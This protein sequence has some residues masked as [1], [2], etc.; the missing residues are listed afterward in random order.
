MFIL[1]IV[2]MLMLLTNNKFFLVHPIYPSYPLVRNLDSVSPFQ[3]FPDAFPDQY[4]SYL[5][6]IFTR[7]VFGPAGYDGPK[8]TLF[9]FGE[10]IHK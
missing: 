10:K 9:I 4:L 5:D 6:K 1:K 2:F 3:V 8:Q 7:V